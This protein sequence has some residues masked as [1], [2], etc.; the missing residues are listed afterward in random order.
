MAAPATPANLAI[1]QVASNAI[2]LSWDNVAGEDGF[3]LWKSY[4]SG[5]TYESI[6]DIPADTLTWYDMDCGPSTEYYYKVSAYNTDG[7]SALSASVNDTT[8]AKSAED[9]FWSDLKRGYDANAVYRRETVTRYGQRSTASMLVEDNA[10]AADEVPAFSQI[11]SAI[12]PTN[13]AYVLQIAPG[14]GLSDYRVAT[15]G[16]AISLTDGG[17]QS[18]L[19]IAVDP[20]AHVTDASES[21]TVT[22]PGDAPADADALRDDLVANTI[23]SIESALNALGVKVN[24][25]I[26]ALETAKLMETS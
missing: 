25:I 8:L 24:A 10:T 23:P 14:G 22:D 9:S 5:V 12:P 11:P 3:H 4:D 18:T 20:A 7:E 15:A 13:A 16:D 26:A 1:D 6:A 2:K 17:A 19:T 21:H